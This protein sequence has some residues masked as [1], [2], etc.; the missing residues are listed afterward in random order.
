MKC[1][2]KIGHL[3]SD[4]L[5]MYGDKGNIASLKKR[6]EWRGFEAIVHS[7]KQGEK[8]DFFEYDIILLGGGGEKDELLALSLLAQQKEELKAYIEQGGVMLCLCGGLLMLG[9]YYKTK[10]KNIPALGI[11]DITHEIDE[12][13]IGNVVAEL[14]LNGETLKIAGFENH[15][16]RL[17]I[18]GY[19]PFAKV[20]TGNGN[21]ANDKNEGL[22]YKN[23]FGTFLHGPILP[24]NP[25]LTDYILAKAIEKKYGEVPK[26]SPLCD[27]VEN[28]AHD[29]A[30][31]RFSGEM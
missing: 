12:R 29:Y 13:F 8:I 16:A 5:N 9:D 19:E 11:L 6:M 27:D 3:F 14:Q 2:L 1:S 17:N 21:N 15:A 24:K 25:K 18:K 20:I 22:V 4:L 30:I 28:E 31:K 26:L 23:L 7:H 10:E